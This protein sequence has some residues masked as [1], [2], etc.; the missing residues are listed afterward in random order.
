[1]DYQYIEAVS[2]FDNLNHNDQLVQYF[3]II[4]MDDPDILHSMMSIK[5]MIYM[6]YEINEHTDDIAN[7]SGIL[8]GDRPYIKRGNL[9]KYHVP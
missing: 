1:M 5:E 8:T 6:K 4:G 2:K 3:S 9:P 7:N